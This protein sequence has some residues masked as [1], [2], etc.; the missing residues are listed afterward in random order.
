MGEGILP[1]A[2][3]G[4]SFTLSKETLLFASS[5]AKLIDVLSALMFGPYVAAGVPVMTNSAVLAGQS[6][7][8]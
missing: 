2:R 4:R 5:S 3:G 6:W 7:S 1:F 8:T